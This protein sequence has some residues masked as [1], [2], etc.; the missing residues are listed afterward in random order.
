MAAFS[1]QKVF[2]I[3]KDSTLLTSSGLLSSQYKMRRADCCNELTNFA[4]HYANSH[5]GIML[6][7][8]VSAPCTSKCTLNVVTPGLP[9]RT[10]Y[11]GDMV[12]IQESMEN[13]L[14]LSRDVF[15]R[16]NDCGFNTELLRCHSTQTKI[17]LLSR[18]STTDAVRVYG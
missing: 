17:P 9:L 11:I 12:L 7:G 1:F 14:S 16:P 13:L 10:D 6:S 18:V 2:D 5:F 8:L 15:Q 4:T 3:L